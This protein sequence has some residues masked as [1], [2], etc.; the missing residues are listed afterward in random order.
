MIWKHNKPKNQQEPPRPPKTTAKEAELLRYKV[1]L[2]DE[3]KRNHP[4]QK[5][6]NHSYES[7]VKLYF[8]Q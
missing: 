5:A 3:I 1:Q 8:I 6:T 4:N 7:W 2:E